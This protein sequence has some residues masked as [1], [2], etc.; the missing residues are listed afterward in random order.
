MLGRSRGGAVA[1]HKGQIQALAC[2]RAPTA[3][4]E[5]RGRALCGSGAVY[6][7]PPDNDVDED[8]K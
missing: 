7:Q 4:S 2:H 3:A 8:N 5:R 6:I 1:P